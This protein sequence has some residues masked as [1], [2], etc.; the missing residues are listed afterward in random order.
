MRDTSDHMT[1]ALAY[2]IASA[3]RSRFVALHSHLAH[4]VVT[5]AAVILAVCAAVAV[6]SS[7]ELTNADIL[8]VWAIASFEAVAEFIASNGCARCRGVMGV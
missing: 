4:R 3:V 6:F 7:P 1:D 2:N 5:A 8:A